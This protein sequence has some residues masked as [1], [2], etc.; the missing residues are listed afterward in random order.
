MKI[1]LNKEQVDYIFKIKGELDI[2]PEKR[3]ISIEF[4]KTP[5]SRR[6]NGVMKMIYVDSFLLKSKDGGT[7]YVYEEDNLYKPLYDFFITYMREIKLNQIG[8]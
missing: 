4:R 6:I 2:N 7:R 5:I 8:I 1:L 3:Y